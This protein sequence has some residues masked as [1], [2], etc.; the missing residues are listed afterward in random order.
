MDGCPPAVVALLAVV[1][2]SCGVPASQGPSSTDLPTRK[3]T[4]ASGVVFGLAW[5]KDGS[6]VFVQDP[7][8]VGSGT[9]AP[10]QTLRLDPKSGAVQ[11][12][13][14]Q[15]DVRCLQSPFQTPSAL[16]DGRIA[17][18]EDCQLS[19]TKATPDRHRI[20][21]VGSMADQQQ[22]LVANVP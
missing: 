21:G 1:F 2:A 11:R 13:A 3:V 18:S 22:V 4:A 15:P 14:V 19:P 8:V 17:L 10:Y 6:L 20:V 12:V 16:P 5:L 9:V 7:N